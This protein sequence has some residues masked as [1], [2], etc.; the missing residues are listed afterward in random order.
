MIALIVLWACSM[1]AQMT[2]YNINRSFTGT[3]TI[4]PFN[5]NTYS[6]GGAAN[7]P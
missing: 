3:D 6:F 1:N 2:T 4:Q 7:T 5:A